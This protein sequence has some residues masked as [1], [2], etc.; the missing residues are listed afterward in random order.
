MHPHSDLDV[1]TPVGF[2]QQSRERPWKL[3]PFSQRRLL[4]CDR[5]MSDYMRVVI[6]SCRGW[7]PPVAFSGAASR[8]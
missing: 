4:A 2:M 6:I 1:R 5:F 8:Y 3:T 7:Q